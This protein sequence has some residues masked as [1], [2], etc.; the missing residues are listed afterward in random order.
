[1][2]PGFTRPEPARNSPGFS[3]INAKI[4][5]RINIV[6]TPGTSPVYPARNS[7]G[8][9]PVSIWR[10]RSSSSHWHRK[11]KRLAATDRHHQPPPRQVSNRPLH[12]AA[13]RPIDLLARTAANMRLARL[14]NRLP[15]QTAL[16]ARQT[17]R[18]IQPLP[19]AQIRLER[20]PAC[21]VQRV[22]LGCRNHDVARHPLTARRSDNWRSAAGLAPAPSQRSRPPP[23]PTSA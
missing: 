16:C 4:I 3:L 15:A 23:A 9:R 21:P 2:L 1:M 19:D 18:H 17:A 10:D 22:K 6:I 20:R 11:N 7:P 5:I 13:R 14:A 8:T 12:R